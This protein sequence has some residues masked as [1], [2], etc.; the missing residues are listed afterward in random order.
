MGR[1]DINTDKLEKG[2]RE[3]E[4]FL[5][6]KQLNQFISYYELLIEWNEFMNL[7]AITEFDEVVTKHFMDSLSLVKACDLSKEMS[8]IDVGTGAGFP[9]IPLKIAFPNLKL[10]F[11]DSLHK[12]IHFLDVIVQKLDLSDA[13]TIHGRA[14][15]FAKRDAYRENYD[16]CVSRAVANLTTLSEYC[17]PFVK[18]GGLFISYKSEKITE[19]MKE[20]EK[21]IELMGGKYSKQV[22]LTLPF[23]DIYRNLFVIEKVRETPEKYPRKAGIPSKEPLFG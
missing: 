9:G 12:R 23:S 18:P 13:D 20:A 14:E 8:M 22:E 16:M 6:D 5:S 19:E 3:L 21:A 2:L 11:L 7:T 10:T 4:I 15:D 17:I 1:Q